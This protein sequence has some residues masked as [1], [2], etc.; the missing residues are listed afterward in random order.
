MNRLNKVGSFYSKTNLLLT[1]SSS[2]PT[3]MNL[4]IEILS[5]IIFLGRLIDLWKT[6]EV[7][8][9]LFMYIVVFLILLLLGRSS[10]NGQNHS[11]AG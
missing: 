7:H 9:P 3:D 4:D 2:M 8:S 6:K 10:K 1:S 5:K 11:M